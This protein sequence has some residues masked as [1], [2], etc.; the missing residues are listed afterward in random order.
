MFRIRGGAKEATDQSPILL[1]I[2]TVS[3]HIEREWASV[4]NYIHNPPPMPFQNAFDNSWSRKDGFVFKCGKETT[5][6][7]WLLLLWIA[8]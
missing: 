8:S 3:M 2:C 6:T 1:Y 5:I 4:H 7:S